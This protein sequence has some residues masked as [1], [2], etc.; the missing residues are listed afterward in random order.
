MIEEKVGEGDTISEWMCDA[1]SERLRHA[2]ESHKSRFRELQVYGAK[3]GDGS[4]FG[5]PVERRFEQ[6]IA[7]HGQATDGIG[8]PGEMDPEVAALMRS[9]LTDIQYRRLEAH[10]TEPGL[11]MERLAHREGASKQAIHTSIHSAMD[12]V[13]D[14]PEAR[15]LIQR[16]ATEQSF[17]TG[18]S[19]GTAVG[20]VSFDRMLELVCGGRPVVGEIS[21][22]ARKFH[23]LLARAIKPLLT[24][25]QYRR[26]EA[27]LVGGMPLRMIADEEDCSATSVVRAVRRAKMRLGASPEVMRALCQLYQE[28]TGVELDTEALV[29]AVQGRRIDREIDV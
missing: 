6:L 11:T 3:A 26:L 25:V 13:L 22:D 5:N 9:L 1:A 7:R 23:P 18:G 24:R 21:L 2:G 19:M 8:G 16:K 10:L 17:E 14:S 12:R 29:A 4:D 15:E 28:H 27:H 20:S